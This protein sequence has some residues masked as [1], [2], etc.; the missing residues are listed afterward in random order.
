MSAS[1]L[2]HKHLF[3]V[4]SRVTFTIE[5]HLER[6]AQCSVGDGDHLWHKMPITLSSNTRLCQH[7]LFMMISANTIE[8]IRSLLGKPSIEKHSFVTVTNLFLWYGTPWCHICHKK[9][10][11]LRLPLRNG[12]YYTAELAQL[13]WCLFTRI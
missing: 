13:L 12:V 7:W 4:N 6:R 8:T 11:L 5:E 1:A 2:S 10:F 9:Y 3:Y